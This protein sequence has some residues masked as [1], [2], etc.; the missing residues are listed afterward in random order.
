MLGIF[1]F[2]FPKDKNLFKK[3][4]ILATPVI[5]SNISRVSMG[6]I[7]MAMIG[8]LGGSAIAAVG[9]S[10]MVTWTVISLGIAFR[11]GTQ[12]FVSRRLGQKK[13]DQCSL[14]MRN[15][16]VFALLIGLPIT[17]ICYFYTIPIM[18]FFLDSSTDAFNLSIDYA[19]YG[20]L[21]TYFVYVMFIFQGF[22]TGIE[23]TKIHMKTTL[24]ANILNIYL[25]VGLIFGTDAV[26]H[27]FNGSIF[28]IFGNLWSIY[29]FP[30]LGV[31]G[32][33]IGTFIAIIWQ[34]IHYS[35]YLFKEEIIR[36]KVFDP[37]IDLE[38]LKKQLI[39]AYPIAFQETLVMLSI[40][41]FYKIIGIIGITQLAAT[42]V[43]FKIMHTS[44]MPAI[45][46]G[47]ACATLVGKYLGEENPQK[48]ESSIKESLRGSFL[49]MGSVGII[50]MCFSEYI[51]PLFTN[52]QLV[53]TY[54]I[55]GLKFVG[56][57]QFVDAICFTLWFAMTGAGDTKIP[58]IVDVAS[59]WILFVPACYISGIYL[60]YGFWGP[61][62]SFGLH[63]T[64]FSIFLFVRFKKGKWKTI[65]V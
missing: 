31:K 45:G 21:G 53:I 64:F 32:A 49:I 60:G 47:Q 44:F 6:I 36:Y 41:I 5:I 4:F 48:A 61:W 24:S 50:F 22:Y 13:Y 10:G 33:A 58:A 59:H 38:M 46:V 37:T 23:E 26:L 18:S 20:F 30:E 11:T 43:I 51:V 39:V 27:F 17:L 12:T 14:A 34:C 19:K 35:L 7:D 65:K 54:A 2:L 29:Y 62:I 40:T 55:P 28:E 1:K 52:D 42:Q 16:H 56:I 57:L 25:N 9:M 8:H 3:V 63:L 15:I